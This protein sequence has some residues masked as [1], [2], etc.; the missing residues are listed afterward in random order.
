MLTAATEITPCHLWITQNERS[1]LSMSSEDNENPWGDPGTS[2]TKPEYSCPS[3]AQQS[4]AQ[5]IWCQEWA[6]HYQMSVSWDP[7]GSLRPRPLTRPLDQSKW[8]TAFS[9]GLETSSPNS[10]INPNPELGQKLDRNEKLIWRRE[11]STRQWWKKLNTKVSQQG[12]YSICKVNTPLHSLWKG[13]V[14]W[15]ILKLLV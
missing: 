9:W 14:T 15:M 6:A 2:G 7:E 10:H 5:N 11:Q 4:F 12:A 3:G 1:T 13:G 8:D